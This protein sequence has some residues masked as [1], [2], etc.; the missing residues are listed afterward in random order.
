M[1]FTQRLLLA[2]KKILDDPE[3][4]LLNPKAVV[5]K[6]AKFYKRL[7]TKYAKDGGLV[8][9]VSFSNSKVGKTIPTI[10]LFSG[11]TC[12]GAQEGGCLPACYDLTSYG[13]KPP[14]TI[15]RLIN[16]LLYQRNPEDF[17]E[18]IAE[19]I[20]PRS[21]NVIRFFEGGDIPDQRFLDGV[22]SLANR[23]PKKTFF[24]YTKSIYFDFSKRPKNVFVN[25]SI[26]ST[27]T[28][29]YIKNALKLADENRFMIAWA[30]KGDAPD[31]GRKVIKCPNQIRDEIKCEDCT[32]CFNE[33]LLDN[34]LPLMKFDPHGIGGGKI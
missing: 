4:D 10:S 14:V 31:F 18:Q 11:L 6:M 26:M 1:K 23:F 20:Y 28:P 27:S 9:Q 29:R 12:P 19:R 32:L 25:V 15:C 2:A 3:V 33:K 21:V 8:L 22:F 34:L 24:L 16:T 7:A 5:P 13:H 17:F 30:G